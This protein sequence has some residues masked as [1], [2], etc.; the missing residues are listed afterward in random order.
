MNR[1]TIEKIIAQHSDDKVEPGSVVWMDLDVRS[2]RD[3]AGANVVENFERNYPGEPLDDKQKTFFTFDCNVPANT[4]PYANNQQQCRAFAQKHGIKVFDVNAG[5]GSHVM[6]D[7]GIALPGST[8]V[9]TDSHLNILGAVGC[10]G[11]GMGDQDIAFAFQSGRTWFEVPQTMKVIIEGELPDTV[12]ARDLTLAI[13]GRLGSKGALGWAIE[14]QGEAIDHLDL[15]GRITLS[16]MVTEMGGIVGL[17]E[18]DDRIIG[19][20][21]ETSGCDDIAPVYPDKNADYIETV[22]ID[23]SNL[24]PV[25]AVPSRPDNVVPVSDVGEVKVDSV[26]IGSCTNGRF[27]DFVE[28][29]DIIKGKQVARGVMAKIVPATLQ[30]YGQ[31]LKNGYIDQLF[32]AGFIISNPGC[33]GCASGQIGMTGQ[34]EVQ[35]STSNRNFKGKQGDG[36]TY[37]ASPATAAASAIAGKIVAAE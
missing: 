37:L 10:F 14:F 20:L 30:V 23:I 6:I 5:I 22:V 16:S 19:Y 26:F 32:D 12:S 24:E 33:G 2:A 8:V 34:N 1:T 27:E 3:F 9:G 7:E 17:I 29:A 18:P 21:K 15:A 13:V 31:L 36:L 35:V 4:I 11:Q 25:I 28:V